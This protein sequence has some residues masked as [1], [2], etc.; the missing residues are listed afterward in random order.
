ML[1]SAPSGV[2]NFQ[3][4]CR[5][6]TPFVPI[7]VL[8]VVT[9]RPSIDTHTMVTALDFCEETNLHP[10]HFKEQQA[11]SRVGPSSGGVS[12]R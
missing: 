6:R 1:P 10:I 3:N 4:H 5:V 7:F 11:A 2:T 8:C 12:A 9:G